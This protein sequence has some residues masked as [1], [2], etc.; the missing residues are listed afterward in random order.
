VSPAVGLRPLSRSILDVDP[1][2]A[3]RR[4]IGAWLIRAAEDGSEPRIARIVEVEAYG[5]GS[6]LA[7]HARA[8]RTQRNAAMYAAPGIA[9]VYLVYG[10]H[11]CLNVVTEADG[12]PAAL[13][14]RAVEPLTGLDAMRAARLAANRARPVR[15]V[16]DVRLAAG[17]GLVGAAFSIDR[18]V[19]GLDLCDPASPLRLESPPR[20]EPVPTIIA[21]PRIGISYA[22]EPWASQP[23]RL[24]VDGSPAISRSTR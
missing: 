9:Y 3:A 13:L 18:S 7:S 15:D 2:T 20:D 6:D 17:P 23:W 12:E 21:T 19:N 22:G 4:L 14:V 8:G 1:P 11:H 10:M 16:P 24:L 5:G